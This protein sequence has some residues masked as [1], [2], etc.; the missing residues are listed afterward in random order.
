[1]PVVKKSALV[2]FS[3]A[4][5]YDLVY[6]FEAYPEF[7]PWCNN[8]RLISCTEDE[9]CGELEV[10][11]VGIN[12]TFSTRNRLVKNERMDIELLEGPFRKLQ[13][14]WRFTALQENACKIELELDF[15]FSGRLINSAFGKVFSQIANTLVD[16][17]CK[18]AN[19]VYCD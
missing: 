15:E 11:R 13:G 10:S 17:F 2:P 5:M 19:E 3:S 1:M 16:A 4:R 8:S 12:Q 9:I 14:G 18:R 7:L 6:N